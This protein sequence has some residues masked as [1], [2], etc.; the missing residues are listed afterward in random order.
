MYV[1]CNKHLEDAIDD[2]VEV[3]EQPPDLYQL[4]KVTF[5]DWLAPKTCDYCD[6]VP[7]YLVV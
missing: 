5:T 2:F 1:I 6:H 4:D 7:K 3:Y